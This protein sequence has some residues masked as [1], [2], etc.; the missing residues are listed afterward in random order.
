[1]RVPYAIITPFILVI[2]IIGSYSL[3]NSMLDVFITVIFGLIG[4]WLR[5]LKYPLA[6]L[7]VALVLGDSTERELR[8]TLIAGHGSPLYFFDSWISTAML[9]AAV[10]LIL[11][12]LVRTIRRRRAAGGRMA[13]T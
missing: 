8:K 6:P 13:T 11:I 3:N 5:K 1:M 10:V 9:L 7:V 4:Y 2:S 12:P